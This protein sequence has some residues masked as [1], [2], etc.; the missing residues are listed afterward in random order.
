[1]A[2]AVRTHGRMTS[3]DRSDGPRGSKEQVG[4]TAA[5]V[6][7]DL[8]ADAASEA[9]RTSD[10]GRHDPPPGTVVADNA[11][12]QPGRDQPASDIGQEASTGLSEPG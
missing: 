1:M 7:P 5:D 2:W 4:G 9:E 10:R 11:G 6:R 3:Q 8:A 12:Q